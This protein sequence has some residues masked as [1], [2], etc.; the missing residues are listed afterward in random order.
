MT[1]ANY[2]I[3]HNRSHANYE[4]S[5]ITLPTKIMHCVSATMLFAFCFH[6]KSI[7]IQI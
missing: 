2:M 1:Q 5:A 7:T 4:I 3:Y 6:Y